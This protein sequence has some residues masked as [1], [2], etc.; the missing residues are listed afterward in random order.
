MKNKPVSTFKI[1]R[2]ISEEA[3]GGIILIIAT[4][5]ATL[6]SATLGMIWLSAE[7]KKC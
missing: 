1:S 2:F 5:A 7:T 3:Y 4:I 6:I